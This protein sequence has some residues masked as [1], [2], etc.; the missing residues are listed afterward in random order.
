MHLF[1]KFKK[2]RADRGI[3]IN[4]FELLMYTGKILYDIEHT[5]NFK[6]INEVNNPSIYTRIFGT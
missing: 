6:K 4:D 1:S 5:D 2:I 3:M